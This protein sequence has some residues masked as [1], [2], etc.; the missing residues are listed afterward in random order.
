MDI[1]HRLV[2]L[3]VTHWKIWRRT[4]KYGDPPKLF[5]KS[6]VAW[7]QFTRKMV[8]CP[9]LWNPTHKL[10]QTRTPRVVPPPPIVRTSAMGWTGAAAACGH[11]PPWR[12]DE[13]RRPSHKPAPRWYV[14][15]PP[16][17]AYRPAPLVLIRA[18]TAAPATCGTE[19]LRKISLWVAEK[20]NLRRWP[21]S[22]G[23]SLPE[24]K[25]WGRFH[26]RLC[27]FFLRR[28]S[29]APSFSATTF[30]VQIARRCSL[31]EGASLSERWTQR[32]RS[33]TGAPR[34]ETF[35]LVNCRQP[36]Q[37]IYVRTDNRSVEGAIE[38]VTL[39]GSVAHGSFSEI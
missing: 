11:A 37:F 5:K 39:V 20:W 23:E 10:P 9:N 8:L 36:S 25:E 31:G 13:L 12:G 19:A 24:W 33:R 27:R 21:S 18:S 7:R 2:S 32:D 16:P 17:M 30:A 14:Q 1:L 6:D 38:H 35:Q 22:V 15:A 26:Q 29:Q 28:E 34:K 4:Q 3:V